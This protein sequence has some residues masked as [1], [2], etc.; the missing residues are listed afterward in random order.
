MGNLRTRAGQIGPPGNDMKSSDAIQQA[1]LQVH[2]SRR[3][4][5]TATGLQFLVSA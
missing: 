5:S 2:S 1:L 3:G 4:H